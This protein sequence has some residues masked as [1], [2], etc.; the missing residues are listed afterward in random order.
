MQQ[1][2]V[3]LTRMFDGDDAFEDA[4]SGLGPEPFDDDL[5]DEF[6]DLEEDL[7]EV[8]DEEDEEIPGVDLV[9]SD[10]DILLDEGYEFDDEEEDDPEDLY[11]DD[12]GYDYDDEDE[13]EDEG[14]YEDER[15]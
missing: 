8:E 13:D 5:E 11:G 15:F 14:Y 10:D 1:E 4:G 12:Y 9:I 7:E 2:T 3:S 6:D